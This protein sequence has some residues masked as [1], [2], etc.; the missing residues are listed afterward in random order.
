MPS[1]SAFNDW[2]RCCCRTCRSCWMPSV[3]AFNDSGC[4]TVV[5]LCVFFFV[6]V[7]IFYISRYLVFILLWIGWYDTQPINTHAPKSAG[8]ASIHACVFFCPIYAYFLRITLSSSLP[9]VS[10]VTWHA[11]LSLPTTV[12]AFVLVARKEKFRVK[13]PS[14]AS[15]CVELVCI[16]TTYQYITQHAGC[17]ALSAVSLYTD[18]FVS[19]LDLDPNEHA[20]VTTSNNLLVVYIYMYYRID[21]SHDI[22]IEI[23]RICSRYWYRDIPNMFWILISRY[24]EYVLNID[25]EISRKYRMIYGEF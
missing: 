12:R 15:P 11:L 17:E 9:F 5:E 13:F 19:G 2:A 1:F 4:T 21:I 16:Y 6:K 7:I 14:L 24:P 22:G 25:I 20:H 3:S 23:S 8:N 10:G 18:A